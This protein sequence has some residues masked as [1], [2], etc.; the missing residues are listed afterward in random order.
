MFGKVLHEGFKPE[1]SLSRLMKAHNIT[2]FTIKYS[3]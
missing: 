3:I 1:R 2:L